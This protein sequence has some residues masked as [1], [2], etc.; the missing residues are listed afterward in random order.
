MYLYVYIYVY[1]YM[2]VCVCVCVRACV[3]VCA[4]VCVVLF[5]CCALSFAPLMNVTAA[6]CNALLTESET[7]CNGWRRME[8]GVCA[9]M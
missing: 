8:T 7:K 5:L 3:C 1:I 9:C 6:S 2:Y 4:C